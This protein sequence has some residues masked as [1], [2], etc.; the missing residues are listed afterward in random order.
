MPVQDRNT[1]R[2][3]QSDSQLTHTGH[4]QRNTRPHPGQE[5]PLGSQMISSYAPGVL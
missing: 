4:S 1:P 2:D 3:R 5:R